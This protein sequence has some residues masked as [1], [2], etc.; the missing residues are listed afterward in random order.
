VRTQWNDAAVKKQLRERY[1]L[2]CKKRRRNG[3]GELD[4]ANGARGEI[5]DIVLDPEE[6]PI[7]NERIVRLTRPPAYVLVKLTRTRAA[8]LEGLE[9][10]VIPIEPMT[11]AYAFTDLFNIYVALSRSSGR[12]SIRI[13]RDFDEHV[14]FKPLP[15]ALIREDERLRSLDKQTERWWAALTRLQR[16]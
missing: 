8:Q 2:A 7:A 11:A 10:S 6:P 15:E 5:V 9:E 13:L 16:L 4:I 14:L 12:N 1:L 3:K